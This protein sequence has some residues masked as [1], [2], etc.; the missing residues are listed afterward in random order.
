MSE[1]RFNKTKTSFE[2]F[3]RRGNEVRW[4]QGKATFR[5]LAAGKSNESVGCDGNA[6]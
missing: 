4:P 5:S 3:F 2:F 1:R 6:V